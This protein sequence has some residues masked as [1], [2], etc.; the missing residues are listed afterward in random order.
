MFLKIFETINLLLKDE[1]DL[2]F[3]TYIIHKLYSVLFG[4]VSL[5][6]N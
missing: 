1:T 6:N 3:T 5:V 2:G 4:I